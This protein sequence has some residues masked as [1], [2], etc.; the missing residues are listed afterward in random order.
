[1]TRLDA[2]MPPIWSHANPIDIAGDADAARYATAMDALIDDRANDAVLVMNVPTALASSAGAAEAIAGVIKRHRDRRS[3]AKPVL[4]V[5]LG[6]SAAATDTFNAAGIASYATEA[7]AVTGF[8]H[9]VRYRH[10][11]RLLMA[12]PPSLPQDFVPDTAEARAVIAAA[13]RDGRHWLDPIEAARLFGAYGIDVT[14]AHLARDPDKA[15]AA[16]KPYFAAGQAVTVKILRPTS[17]TNRRS[18]ASRSISRRSKPCAKPQPTF[19]AGRGR[20]SRRRASQA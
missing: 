17:C 8:M 2:V 3:P 7:D 4:A 1:M 6:G 5:W 13:L 14:P 19:C 9:V 15:A 18:A 20:R 12:A 16:A 10:A 11:L